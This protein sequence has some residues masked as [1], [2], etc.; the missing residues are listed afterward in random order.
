MT[1]F[2]YPGPQC[3]YRLI[4]DL[5]LGTL[6]RS[7]SRS[8]AL[9][10][11]VSLW[12]DLQSPGLLSAPL[13]T[14][15]DAD[16]D[17]FW[18]VRHM[19][20][21]G[22]DKRPYKNVYSYLADRFSFFGPPSDY[23]AFALESDAELA[24][25]EWVTKKGT[26]TLRSMLEFKNKPK[27]QQIFY[28]W[29]RKAYLLKAGEDAED[30]DVPEVVRKGMTPE[31]VKRIKEVRGSIRVKGIKY[32]NFHAGGYNFRPIK[33]EHHYILG[34]LSDHATGTAV[35]IDDT[36][37]AQIG[38]ADWEFIEK[39]TGKRFV[40]AGR[41][42]TEKDAAGLWKDIKDLNELFVKKM[43]SE[44]SRI[45]QE[46]AEH[47][48]KGH[49]AQSPLKEILGKDHEKLAE[50][51]EKGFFHLPLDFVLEMHAH[52]FTWGAQFPVPDLHH[53]QIDA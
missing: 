4:D 5:D 19:P 32:E 44:I 1:S 24:D 6:C 37:N 43:A 30:A 45:T 53:F 2:R 38:K 40:R 47:H 15:S 11:N 9:M 26:V 33:Q 46:R 16:R 51:S 35:D 21:V 34:T 39:L 23:A 31:L 18:I 12:Q 13:V 48:A 14:P 27:Q 49:N 17:E 7:T 52:G 50:Y 42:K 36:E 20:V 8:P 10:L 25:T 3:R 28:R 41:W 22:R 29:T